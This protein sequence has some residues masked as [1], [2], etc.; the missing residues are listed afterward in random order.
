MNHQLNHQLVIQCAVA[1]RALR[2]LRYYNNLWAPNEDPKE[3]SSM[4]NY[5][6]NR[7][8]RPTTSAAAVI[9]EQCLQQHHSP[10]PEM[11]GEPLAF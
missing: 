2:A 5:D 4:E 1:G 9:P 11:G 8:H 6:H 3:K 10:A 7:F